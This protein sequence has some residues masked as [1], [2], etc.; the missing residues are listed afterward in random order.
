MS[1]AW[2]T[3]P[4]AAE[5]LFVNEAPAQR[6]LRRRRARRRMIE[7]RLSRVAAQIE[8]I[9]E[10][11]SSLR[12]LAELG[13]DFQRGL[14]APQRARWLVLEDA[15]LEHASRLHRAYF[16]AG[17]KFGRGACRSNGEAPLEQADAVAT[18]AQLIVKLVRRGRS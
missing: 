12:R 5:L 7:Q 9:D 3:L 4:P 10:L 16:E 15:L 1:S 18:L 14:D 8:Q 11:K 2:P 6:R 17:V 13:D